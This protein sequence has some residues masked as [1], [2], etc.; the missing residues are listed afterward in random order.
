MSLFG[1]NNIKLKLIKSLFPKLKLV[2]RG[3][4]VKISGA[5]N[6]IAKFKQKFTLFV[7]VISKY[8]N[9]S[10][11]EIEE[12]VASDEQTIKKVMQDDVLLYTN[13][14]AA[15][16]AKTVNQRRLVLAVKVYQCCF[17][18]KCF[19]K[20]ES[21]THNSNSSSCRSRGEPWVFAR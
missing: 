14:G 17:S 19:K 12:L 8:G 20:Q 21:K 3:N 10:E 4:K 13:K 9:I 6:D 18:S 11:S 15:I 5:K 16:R 2:A 7:E 1:V